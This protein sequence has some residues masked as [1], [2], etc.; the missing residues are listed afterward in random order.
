MS[1]IQSYDNSQALILI[2]DDLPQNLQVLGS[3]LRKSKYQIAVA[4]NGQQAIDVLKN[5]SPDLILLDVMMP[6]I[7]GH[8]VCRRLKEQDSTR[9]ISIIFLTAKSETDDIVKGFELGAVDYITKPFNATELLAR[10]KTH[11]ELKKNRDVILNL[12]DELEGKNRILEKLA[13]TDSLTRI[14]NH[15]HIIDRLNNEICAAQR[16][17]DPLTITM[18]DIDHFKSINDTYGHQVGDDVL[19]EVTNTIKEALREIDI[20]GRY[21]GEEFLVVMRKTD[22]HGC[23]IASER[24]RKNIEALTWDHDNLH[25]NIS[26]GI[27]AIEHEN[28]SAASMIKRADECLY[29]AKENGRN[30]IECGE[31]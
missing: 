29:L 10:V 27:G 24:I 3:I 30:R 2:V 17:G 25:V 23:F 8:E 18:F 21:G 20:I 15:S 9:D 14:F 12:I 22:R 16:H 31:K 1:S 19:V 6:G 5:I 4:T 28:D 13:V 26:G 7:D 11:V